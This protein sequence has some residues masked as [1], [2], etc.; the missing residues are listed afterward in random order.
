MTTPNPSLDS[1][2][3][4]RIYCNWCEQVTNHTLE[5]SRAYDRRSDAESSNFYG[6]YRLWFC[7]GCETCTMEDY[8]TH[9]LYQRQVAD[10]EFVQDYVSDYH[11]EPEVGF[12]SKKLFQNLPPT[13]EKLYGEV[14]RAHNEN[15]HILCSA[16]LRGLIEG[17]CADKSISGRNLEQKIDGMTALLP[18]NIVANLHGF[19]F[20]GNDAVHEL[21]APN[22]FTLTLAL[23][24]I[25]DI[26][27]FLYALDYKVSL[28][29]RLKGKQTR[30]KGKDGAATG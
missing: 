26:L 5:F 21:E 28:L 20:I 19:R 12:R 1:V 22:E 13:L 16:G 23:D 2:K 30:V 6:E 15:L 7:A 17:I 25:E 14:I 4:C 10:S 9:D 27:N 24:V 29:D 18:E 3:T 8:Y 11:P